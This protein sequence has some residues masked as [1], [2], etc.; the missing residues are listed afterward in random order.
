M[1]IHMHYIHTLQLHDL[2]AITYYNT[3]MQC[4]SVHT[5]RHTH[6]GV[7]TH[8]PAHYLHTC[9]TLPVPVPHSLHIPAWVLFPYMPAAITCPCTCTY[10]FHGHLP[11]GF[12]RDY[13]HHTPRCPALPHHCYL[14]TFYTCRTQPT[15]P[16]HHSLHLAVLPLPW[17]CHTFPS[18]VLHCMPFLLPTLYHTRYHDL[19]YGLLCCVTYLY[20][21]LHVPRTHAT[22]HLLRC[23]DTFTPYTHRAGAPLHLRLPRTLVPYHTVLGSPRLEVVRLPLPFPNLPTPSGLPPT[24]P[25][26]YG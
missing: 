20:Y 18:V 1:H 2:P 10:S 24:C 8:P 23:A 12:L 4:S 9:C 17:D 6:L 15:C 16:M 3:F 7:V 22:R 25:P 19:Y 13:T 26:G 5:T 11:S 14:H 21:G